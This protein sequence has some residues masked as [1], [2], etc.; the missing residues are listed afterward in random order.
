MSSPPAPCGPAQL[1]AARRDGVALA[2]LLG[3][4]LA[5]ALWCVRVHRDFYRQHAPFYDSCSYTRQMADVASITGDAGVG[6]GIRHALSGNVALPFLQVVA[7]S[8][9]VQP[10]RELGVWM[11]WIWLFALAMSSYW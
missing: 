7:L 9:L 3:L 10:T 2:I 8:A 11:Q 6:A 1:R 4:M 5:Q